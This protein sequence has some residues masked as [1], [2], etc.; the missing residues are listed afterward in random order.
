VSRSVRDTA[1]WL[2]VGN[3]HDSRDPL[4]LPRIE[5]WEAGLGSWLDSMRGA[6]VA[7]LPAF[8][9][10]TVAPAV[11][12]V[13]E[14]LGSWLTGA[15]ALRRVDA[16]VRIPSMGT[17]WAL[18]GLV[19]EF[20]ALGDRWPACEHE[21]TPEVRAGLRF[22][23]GR[24]GLDARIRLE[25][26]RTEL[27]EAMATLFDTV[28]LVVCA[29]NPDVAFDADGPLPDTFGGIASDLGN[30]GRL[31]IPSN[32]YGNPA[33]SIPAGTIGGLPVGVQ[34]L[35]PHHREDLLLDVALLVERERPWPLLA[36][37]APC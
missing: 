14:E 31:T 22:A 34:V 16:D 18:A 6:R 35:A 26:R 24:Y 21:L 15:L 2:D 25:K 11:V 30:N 19:S 27:V 4:S 20:A 5:G 28:D 3:G 23:D 8:A 12:G 13:V 9:G 32:I 36:P 37:G 17:A 1:R 10:A 29:T 7:V 33:I